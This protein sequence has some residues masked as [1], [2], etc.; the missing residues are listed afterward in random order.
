MDLRFKEM[1]ALIERNAN[2][3]ED[4]VSKLK[5]WTNDLFHK[6]EKQGNTIDEIGDRF[7][8]GASDSMDSLVPYGDWESDSYWRMEEKEDWD[9]EK[10]T[11]PR[12]FTLK[13]IRDLIEISFSL[14]QMRTALSSEISER[15]D[16][17]SQFTN[18]RSE[19]YSFKK[20]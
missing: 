5:L 4:D 14:I 3:I 19:F 8:T 9:Q 13:Q 12:N 2:R 16:L 18:L 17:S 15:E 6:L 20:A 1:H 11:K 10:F 7:L